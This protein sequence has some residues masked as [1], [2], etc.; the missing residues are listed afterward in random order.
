MRKLALLLLIALIP[1]AF[2]EE[3]LPDDLLYRLTLNGE[4]IDVTLDGGASPFAARMGRSGT[5]L[6][7]P[8]GDADAWDV[9]SDALTSLSAM[10]VTALR[11]RIGEATWTIKTKMRRSAAHG[12]CLARKGG[13]RFYSAGWRRGGLDARRRRLRQYRHMR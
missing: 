9:P 6:L 2:A 12:R 10:G 1:F 11:L 13:R 7:V 3:E 5:L 4:V 8:A